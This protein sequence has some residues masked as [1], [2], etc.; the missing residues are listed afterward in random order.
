MPSSAVIWMNKM[1]KLLR[2]QAWRALGGGWR[3]IK[4]GRVCGSPLWGVLGTFM[5]VWSAGDP[6]QGSGETDN[7]C[8]PVLWR[9]WESPFL[10]LLSW[11]SGWCCCPSFWCLWAGPEEPS[12]QGWERFLLFHQ[13]LDFMSNQCL[14]YNNKFNNITAIYNSI[15]KSSKLTFLR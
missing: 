15:W 1:T 2:G 10:L 12:S 14:F 8:C 5:T 4:R 11:A 6:V 9:C 3:W 13:I 7:S